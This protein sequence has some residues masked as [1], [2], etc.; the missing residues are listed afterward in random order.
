MK[1]DLGRNWQL[2]DSLENDQAIERDNDQLNHSLILTNEAFSLNKTLG[3]L[4]SCQHRCNNNTRY[5]F[6]KVTLLVFD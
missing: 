1:H 2:A 5:H 4:E 3:N 6:V